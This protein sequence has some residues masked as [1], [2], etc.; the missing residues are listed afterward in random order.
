M[1][2]GEQE[3]K[4]ERT[5]EETYALNLVSEDLRQSIAFTE[6][7]TAKV[8]RQR[9]YAQQAVQD[10]E[11]VV[12]ESK[13]KAQD[14]LK[15]IEAS[16]VR[17]FDQLKTAESE[18]KNLQTQNRQLKLNKEKSD[19]LH[20][21]LEKEVEQLTKQEKH[22][23]EDWMRKVGETEQQLKDRRDQI[24]RV[25]QNLSLVNQEINQLKVQTQTTQYKLDCQ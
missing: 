17:V 12:M 20:R 13:T 24:T 1:I 16:R 6:E 14:L 9:D 8:Q 4:Q 23:R 10:L 7:E 2:A 21:Q 25:I 3:L 5:N 19:A 18:L 22:L 11:G 15:T